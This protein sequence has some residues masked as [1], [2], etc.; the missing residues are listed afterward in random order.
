[1]YGY[2]TGA[3][4]MLATKKTA[5]SFPLWLH[6]GKGLWTKKING[7]MFYFGRDK[8]AALAEYVRVR[9]DLEAGR[10][11]RP[12]PED[13]V[14]VRVLVNKFLTAKRELVT[15]GELTPAVWHQY[16][17]AAEHIIASLGKE[18]EVAGLRPEDFGKLRAATA[19]RLGPTALK[20]FIT[21]TRTIFN[22]AF[23]YEVI[24]KP[25]R[26]GDAFDVPDR[27]QLKLAR[28]SKGKKLISAA[29]CRKMIDAADPQMKA[30]I[31]LG[32]NGGF[33]NIDCARLNPDSVGSWCRV[34]LTSCERR[35]GQIDV[36]SCGRKRS[37]LWT[38]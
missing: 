2:T 4:M 30:M 10:T 1:M 25:V 24:E 27:R 3:E 15:S 11:P 8:D 6:S 5:P 20:C 18:R 26:Y 12:T 38:L 19:A 16:H 22:F 23:T 32:L 37:T 35:P 28:Q 21:Q 34:G 33:G 13:A 7:R 14:T 36:S 31:L 17:A 9:E 29:N